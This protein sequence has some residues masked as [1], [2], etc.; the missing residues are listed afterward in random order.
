[1]RVPG[2]ATA[3]RDGDWKLLWPTRPGADGKDYIADS[4]LAFHFVNLPLFYGL[5]ILVTQARLQS[6]ERLQD[7]FA[8]IAL[9]PGAE[10]LL[11]LNEHLRC[12]DG[13]YLQAVSRQLQAA[14]ERIAELETQLAG[15]T[16]RCSRE[17]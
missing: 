10:E 17:S 6:S 15:Q 1:M 3:I 11:R 9:A 4:A 14:R 7:A 16:G 12:V 5:G 8:A 2:Q 13:I